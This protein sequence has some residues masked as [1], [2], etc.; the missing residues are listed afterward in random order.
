MFEGIF[1]IVSF[2]IGVGVFEDIVVPTADKVN[3]AYVQPSID[4]G[5]EKFQDGVDFFKEKE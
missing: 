4:Y 5:K 2:V 3:T 1:L